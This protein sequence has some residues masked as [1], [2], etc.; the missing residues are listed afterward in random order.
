M[1]VK[2][3]PFLR[4][5]AVPVRGA[6]SVTLDIVLELVTECED[7]SQRNIGDDELASRDRVKDNGWWIDSLGIET[8]Q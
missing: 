4:W 2:R 6:I 3:W 1:T 8:F 5:K 7:R